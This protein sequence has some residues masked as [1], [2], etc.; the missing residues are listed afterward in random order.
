[1]H[2]L[3]SLF[4]AKFAE[5][6]WSADNLSH[7]LIQDPVRSSVVFEL[8]QVSDLYPF[9]VLEVRRP[10]TAGMHRNE[11]SNFGYFMFGKRTKLVIAMVGLPARGKSFV[12]R[13]MAR[14][15][16]WLGMRTQVYNVGSYRRQ[17]LGAHQPV[18]FFDPENPEGSSARLHMAVAALD[19]LVN[20]LDEGGRVAIYDATNS[21]LSRQKLIASRCQQEGFDL[22]WVELVCDDEK[23][24][25]ENIR[26]TKLTSPDYAGVEPEA[27]AAD[28]RQRIAMYKKTYSPITDVSS[29]YVKLIDAGRQI[30]S[31]NIKSYL[32]SKIVFYLSNLHTTSRTIWLSRHGESEFNKGDRIGGDSSLTEEG[33]EYS[34]RLADW[35]M[36]QST[37]DRPLIV[38]TSTLKRTI[39]TA[40]V[41]KKKKE[42]KNMQNAENLLCSKYIPSAKVHLRALDEVNKFFPLHFLSL[43]FFHVPVLKKD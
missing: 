20:F 15:L 3:R 9:A 24:I 18:N 10:Q 8:E 34:R 22:M 2:D 32:Q 33:A 11:P 28:F 6:G 31:N 27:A 37:E 42:K 35:V 16:N 5:S 7:I 38:W 30:I 43:V 17:R 40:Q 29:S 4:F 39:E 14:Y 36:Q 19:D 25:E 21:T 12:A 13:K 1:M 26:E 23:I 41:R